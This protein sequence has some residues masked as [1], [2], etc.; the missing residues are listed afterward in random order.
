[1]AY[2]I[3][4]VTADCYEG[5]SCLINKLNIH[6]ESVLNKV[7]AEITFAKAVKLEAADLP[8]SFDT[9]YYL[10]IHRFLFEDLYEWAGCFRKINISKKG[11]QFAEYEQLEELCNKLFLRLKKLRF[12]KGLPFSAFI[13]EIVDV[14]C[15][16]NMLHPFREGNGRTERVFISQLIRYN[17]YSIDFSEIDTD[18]LM[19]ATIQSAQGITDLLKRIFIESIK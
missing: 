19:I 17:G 12:L 16:L 1:M 6:D 10:S 11:T 13:D 14:Y 18:L 8:D 5:T 2:S 9:G 15:S 4:A 3:N 7:E